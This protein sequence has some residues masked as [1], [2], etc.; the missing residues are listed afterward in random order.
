MKLHPQ[1][2]QFHRLACL[3]AYQARTC[4][5]SFWYLLYVL[6]PVHGTVPNLKCNT[7]N[8]AKNVPKAKLRKLKNK[9]YSIHI[10]P[11]PFLNVFCF[12]GLESYL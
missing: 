10:F 2:M 11:A 9:K 6:D 12:Y 7:G 5:G 1:I 8:V 4:S 3:C